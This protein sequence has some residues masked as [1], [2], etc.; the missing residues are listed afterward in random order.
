MISDNIG[1]TVHIVNLCS[2]LAI[3]QLINNACQLKF[4]SGEEIDIDIMSFLE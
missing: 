3:K 1:I 4:Q 2:P